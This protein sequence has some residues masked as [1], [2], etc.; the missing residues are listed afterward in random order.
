M[1]EMKY[2]SNFSSTA[3]TSMYRSV[4]AKKAVLVLI[5]VL[6]PIF[7]QAGEYIIT[8]GKAISCGR[9]FSASVVTA[10]MENKNSKGL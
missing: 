5:S 7:Q 8:F 10:A 1:L 3:L 2:E 9:K 4:I 6:S